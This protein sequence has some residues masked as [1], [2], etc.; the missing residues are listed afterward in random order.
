MSHHQAVPEF[1]GLRILLVED[2]LLIAMDM[3][4]ALRDLGCEIVGPYGR[5]SDAI[6]AAREEPVDGAIIDL[7]LR[8]E[9]SFPLIEALRTRSVP[10][11]LC[12]GYADLPEMRNQLSGIPKLT[13]P[14]NHEA[15]IAAMR[16]V[17]APEAV[18]G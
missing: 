6:D 10:C 4:D 18:R 7:N 12:S 17:F 14:C 1:N 11:L 9:L 3:E 8:G 5:L 2:D 13:K 15:L 16:A